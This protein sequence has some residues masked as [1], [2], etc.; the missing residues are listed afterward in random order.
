MRGRVCCA[1]SDMGCVLAAPF[2]RGRRPPSRYGSTAAL[3][4][5]RSRE[6]R[7]GGVPSPAVGAHLATGADAIPTLHPLQEKAV[8]V[9]IVCSSNAGNNHNCAKILRCGSVGI[10]A[11]R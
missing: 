5:G 7:A 8:T 11:T 4:G 10:T 2:L 3:V 9:S 6:L 1:P